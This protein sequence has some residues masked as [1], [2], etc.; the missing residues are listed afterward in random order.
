MTP[1]GT[2]AQLASAQAEIFQTSDSKLVLTKTVR[3]EFFIFLLWISRFLSSSTFYL[4]IPNHR[5]TETQTE[6]EKHQRETMFLVRESIR[7]EKNITPDRDPSFCNKKPC[8]S[9]MRNNFR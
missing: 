6:F 1:V 4:V 8:V 2:F 7:V 9:R 5:I 3:R